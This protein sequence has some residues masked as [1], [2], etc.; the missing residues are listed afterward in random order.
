MG[1][2][3]VDDT[4]LS[5]DARRDRAETGEAP[6]GALAL[7]VAHKGVD[8]VQRD[9]GD[10][11]CIERPQRRLGECACDASSPESSGSS[12]SAS[13]AREQLKR[14]IESSGPRR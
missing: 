14:Q 12:A 6:G 4:G 9:R 5:S 7:V 3:G 8:R 1:S 11:D 2:V 10:L 13:I